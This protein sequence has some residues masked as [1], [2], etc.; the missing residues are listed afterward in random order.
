[1][2]TGDSMRLFHKEK[3]DKQEEKETFFSFCVEQI[4]PHKQG[5][6][7]VL[8]TVDGKM[9]EQEYMYLIGP[10]GYEERIEVNQWIEVDVQNNF[11]ALLVDQ[12]LSEIIDEGYIFTNKNNHLAKS[13][14]EVYNPYLHFLLGKVNHQHYEYLDIL[15]EQLA[16]RSYFL[17]VFDYQD[18]P[19]YQIGDKKYYPIYTSPLEINKDQKCQN[20]KSSVYSFDDYSRMFLNQDKI[21][22]I[23]INPYHKERSIV[24]NK[25]VIQ[26]IDQV[27]NK[28]MKTYVQAKNYLK[29]KKRR[30]KYEINHES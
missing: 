27:K 7:F 2:K 19:I 12:K 15:F 11:Y 13:R 18:L 8:G 20:K 30:Q 9:Q 10:Y 29:D 3:I 25:E 24:L 22:G 17:S 26:Y 1:M 16:T 14:E 5:E 4:Y 21:D 23:I 28:N 6:L